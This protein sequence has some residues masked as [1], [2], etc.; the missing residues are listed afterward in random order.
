MKQKEIVISQELSPDAEKII[1]EY[2]AVKTVN[3]IEGFIISEKDF[4]N[5]FQGT[6]A[7]KE[8]RSAK[9]CAVYTVDKC[10]ICWKSYD[11]IINDRSHLDNYLQANYKLCSSCKVFHHGL[12]ELFSVKLDGDIAS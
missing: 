3:Y 11:V 10:D 4:L 8:I 6:Y 5:K 7:Y 9:Y 12:G 1:Q 2:F